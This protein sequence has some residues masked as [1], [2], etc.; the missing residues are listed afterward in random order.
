MRAL[1]A[2]AGVVLLAG[3]SSPYATA[4]DSPTLMRPEAPI[5]QADARAREPYDKSPYFRKAN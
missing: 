2:M 5:T 4:L 3:C 1:L